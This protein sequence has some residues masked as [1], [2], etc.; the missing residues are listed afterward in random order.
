M[1]YSREELKAITDVCVKHDLYIIA[2][3][4]YYKLVFD[5]KEFIS[6]AS[7]GEEVK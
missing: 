5:G 4:I 7:L 3:E 6:V 2:D 1:V